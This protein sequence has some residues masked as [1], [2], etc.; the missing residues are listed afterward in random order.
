MYKGKDLAFLEGKIEFTTEISIFFIIFKIGLYFV[1]SGIV[2]FCLQIL[3]F[4]A[5]KG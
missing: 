2:Y 4:S 1:S 3:F 5:K